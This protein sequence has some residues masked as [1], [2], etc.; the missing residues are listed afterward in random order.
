MK[1]SKMSKVWYF[2]DFNDILRIEVTSQV[3][4]TWTYY[5]LVVSNEDEPQV[6]AA[7][8]G[9]YETWQEALKHGMIKAVTMFNETILE[10][11]AK[12]ETPIEVTE[13]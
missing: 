7:Y 11:I 6:F 8:E 9:K 5:I 1:V 3:E 13:V 2:A 10:V 4:E 12:L